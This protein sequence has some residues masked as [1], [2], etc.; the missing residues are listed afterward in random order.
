[1][2]SSSGDREPMNLWHHFNLGRATRRERQTSYEKQL[3]DMSLKVAADVLITRSVCQMLFCKKKTY[4]NREASYLSFS[5]H[6]QC[7]MCNYWSHFILFLFTHLL[8]LFFETVNWIVLLSFPNN[9]ALTG[10]HY[11]IMFLQQYA[12]I[13]TISSV[14][15]TYK[16][17]L[18]LC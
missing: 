16:G 10:N 1:M 11:I 13:T 15:N 4:F 12:G 5:S 3:T 7:S 8:N 17:F 6:M 14:N 2:D 9:S 18:S